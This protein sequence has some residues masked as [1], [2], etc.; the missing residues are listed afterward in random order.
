MMAVA[1][2]RLQGGDYVLAIDKPRMYA[3]AKKNVLR[4]LIDE[5][6]AWRQLAMI[7]I[8]DLMGIYIQNLQMLAGFYPMAMDVDHRMIV[9]REG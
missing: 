7:V 3:Y 8:D 5:F 4:Q 6:L 1:L 9:G 2:Q